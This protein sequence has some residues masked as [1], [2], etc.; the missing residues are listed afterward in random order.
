MVEEWVDVLNNIGVCFSIILKFI[1]DGKVCDFDVVCCVVVWFEVID[2][3]FSVGFEEFKVVLN[4]RFFVLIVV[5]CVDMEIVGFF[6]EF[7]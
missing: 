1:S 3:E 6:W 7:L 4:V 5:F 2:E